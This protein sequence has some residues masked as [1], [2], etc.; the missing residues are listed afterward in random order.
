[1]L[2]LISTS[3]LFCFSGCLL[4]IYY[5]SETDC[6][7]VSSVNCDPETLSTFEL[8]LTLRQDAC[9]RRGWRNKL[10]ELVR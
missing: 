1:M 4:H 5:E 2:K 10:P 7:F 8:T 6:E 9:K 3:L